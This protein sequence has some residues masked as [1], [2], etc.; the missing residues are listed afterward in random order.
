MV[1]KMIITDDDLEELFK[2]RIIQY[3]NF[4]SNSELFIYNDTVI[5]IYNGDSETTRY[6]INVINNILDKYSILKSIKELVLPNELIIYNNKVVGFSMPY[7]KGITLEKIITD[8]LYS[9]D[10]MKNLFIRL[11][12]I[13]N[14]LDSLPF[15]F[16]IGDMHEKNIIIDSNDKINI[17]DCDSFIINDNK[18]CIDGNYIIGKYANNHYKNKELQKINLPLDYFSLLCVI[19]NYSFG[20]IIEDKISPVDWLKG[21][22]QFNEIRNILDRANKNFVLLESDIN[23]IFSF[24]ENM[25][26]KKKDNSELIKELTRVKSIAKN[27]IKK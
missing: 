21:D 18:L 4:N 2:N 10:D 19:L 12:N 5:K 9:D 6:N 17:I 14:K 15:N 23:D 13:I 27:A 22:S 1:D 11:L 26:Y 24:K 20:N 7:V 25:N 8:K 16:C 3:D